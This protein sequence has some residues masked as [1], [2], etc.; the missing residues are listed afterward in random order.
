[1]GKWHGDL[2]GTAKE[3]F[4]VAEIPVEP[5][6]WTPEDLLLT[7]PKTFSAIYTHK[8]CT[9]AGSPTGL[10]PAL[11]AQARSTWLRVRPAVAFLGRAAEEDRHC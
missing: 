10:S 1:V 6:S 2:G 8:G 3:V 11:V 5:E 9:V 4:K 7:D